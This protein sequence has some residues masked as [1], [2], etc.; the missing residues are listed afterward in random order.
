MDQLI[1]TIFKYK[2]W[3]L[4][5]IKAEKADNLRTITQGENMETRQMTPFFSSIFSALTACNIHFCIWRYWF[6]C[7]PP[8]D[9]FWP[10]K[11]LNFWLKLPIQ[12]AQ[13]TFLESRHPEVTKGPYYVLFARRKIYIFLRAPAH[14]LSRFSFT[15][16]LPAW[17]WI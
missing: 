10:L 7:G 2:W 1:L 8:F 14:V 17:S 13:H 3:M 15:T 11:Y 6:S 9:P 4:L 16:I 5:T 12:T